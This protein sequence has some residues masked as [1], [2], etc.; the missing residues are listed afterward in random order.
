MTVGQLDRRTAWLL[1]AGVAAVLILRF[2]VYR[3]D[4]APVAAAIDSIPMAEKRLARLRQIAATVPGKQEA[5]RQVQAEL[6]S[7]EKGILQ[8]E[9]AAQAQAQL[10]EVI[11]RLART[12]GI[13]ARGAEEL[14]VRELAD[15][16]GEVFVAVTFNCRIEQW[17][18]F[19]AALANEP[20]L[21]SANDVRVLTS[22]PKDKVLNVRLGL[23]GV[24]PRKLAPEKM[25]AF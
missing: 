24:V 9:T 4:A 12:E 20:Q 17:V 13:D 22:N 21:I 25:G 23:S 6:A 19:M 15:A 5:L 1:A 8:A 10:L 11:R 14:R 2:A 3:E 16:Y 7:R 18:N